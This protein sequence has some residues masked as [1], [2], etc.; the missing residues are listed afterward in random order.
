MNKSITALFAVILLAQAACASGDLYNGVSWYTTYKDINGYR[1]EM[2][3]YAFIIEDYGTGYCDGSSGH[4]ASNMHY[5]LVNLSFNLV[6]C[7]SNPVFYNTGYDLP[8]LYSEYSGASPP[9]NNT[10]LNVMWTANDA[11]F[12]CNNNSM[13]TILF[14]KETRGL[15][16][17]IADYNVTH[18]PIRLGIWQSIPYVPDPNNWTKFVSGTW[19]NA[20]K[21]LYHYPGNSWS[22]GYG[23]VQYDTVTDTQYCTSTTTTTSTTSS[24]STSTT[25]LAPTTTTTLADYIVIACANVTNSYTDA[26]V[27]GATIRITSGGYDSGSSYVTGADGLVNFTLNYNLEYMLQARNA[28]NYM[29]SAVKSGFGWAYSSPP[30]RGFYMNPINNSLVYFTLRGSVT[31]MTG[32]ILPGATVHIRGCQV[33]DYYAPTGNYS[34]N[35]IRGGSCT[36]WAGGISGYLDSSPVSLGVLSG[37]LTF[38][39]PL[40]QSVWSTTTMGT[41][42]ST[43]H[44]TYTTLQ[45]RIEKEVDVF[46]KVGDV[47]YQIR[48]AKVS[49]RS[50]ANII[51]CDDS[52]HYGVSI[53]D[54]AYP[55]IEYTYT[56]SATGYDTAYKTTADDALAVEM[57]ADSRYTDCYIV[58]SVKVNNGTDTYLQG[59]AA[60]TLKDCDGNQLSSGAVTS[61]VNG[62]FTLEGMTECGTCYRVNAKYGNYSATVQVT[63]K[64]AE[65]ATQANLIMET[66]SAERDTQVGDIFDFIW[67][68]TYML[69]FI[70]GGLLF[71]VVIV[72]TMNEMEKHG[73][74]APR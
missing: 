45:G 11:G 56:V 5:V 3:A 12:N 19:E 16:L 23:F 54:G 50:S 67:E 49:A 28:V 53:C 1:G 69:A 30:C 7:D 74:T 32:G 26:P 61:D 52:D 55:G 70:F 36:V 40:S 34:F 58:G 62:L 38:N 43:T 15:C 64:N 66:A 8:V 14:C 4:N 73:P 57:T 13:K 47:G 37:N 2:D 25:T 39:I 48:G 51:Y 68:M 10:M 63:T 27:N 42:T 33:N 24:T 21:Y 29:D 41:G 6:S 9:Y 31:N 71:F 18:T 59:G 44:T 65:G 60:I 46:Y 20:S 22:Q 72:K 17:D 35:S